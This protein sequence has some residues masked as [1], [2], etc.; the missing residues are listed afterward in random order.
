MEN[1]SRQVL[2]GISISK[3][4]VMWQQYAHTQGKGTILANFSAREGRVLKQCAT[5]GRVL[6]TKCVPKGICFSLW[7]HQDL[8]Q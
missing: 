3:C 6:N 2:N 5:K 8:C 4:N 1:L 7:L